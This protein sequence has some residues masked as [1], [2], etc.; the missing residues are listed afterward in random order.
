[1]RALNSLV[2]ASPIK[3]L[4][5][6]MPNPSRKP[7]VL[8]IAEA[9]N[10]ESISVA[11]VGWHH[12]RALADVADVHLVTEERNRVAI[13]KT[14]LWRAPMTAL[15]AQA[16]YQAAWKLGLKLR[17]GTGAAWTINSALYT[18][19]YPF[20]ERLVWKRFGERLQRGE[21]D[22]VHR[23]T[24]LSPTT[25]SALA[26]KCARNEIPFILG[27]MNGG[28]AWP[29]GFEEIR[30]K[31]KEWLSHVRWIYRLMPGYTSTRQ[32]ASAI[33]IASLSTWD[34]M[35]ARFQD[36][37]VY[38]P[39]NGIEAERFDHPPRHNFSQPLR[40]AY[41][42]R[43]VPFK[44]PDMAL[45]A[46]APLVR[47]GKVVFDFI[48][49]GP[50]MP[51]LRE[52]VA[53]EKLENGVKLSGWVEHGKVHQRLSESDVF[54]FPSIREFGGAVVVEAMAL[55]LV[56]IVVNYGGPAETVTERTG[57]RVPLG[58]RS[59]IV[60]GLRSV[61]TRLAADPSPLAQMSRHAQQHAL[62][63]FTWAAKAKQVL[64]VY[65]WVLRQRA[66]KPDFG[67]PFADTVAS[68]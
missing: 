26:K 60:A 46:A 18:L 53:R 50:E 19:T 32:S 9:A 29:K 33:M 7:R 24:P 30:R 3:I 59:E 67:R 40:V 10:P 41:L 48:G 47:A 62:Q 38:I 66:D 35:P 58:S 36:K 54:C 49:D 51:R 13:E 27:P 28:L 64:E 11:L 34:E 4:L 52:F 6:H 1:M 37:C 20:F 31:E 21:W 44:G 45:E 14:G 55:G 25:P 2:R 39:E 8:L 61:L 5:A 15:N 42:G 17:G 65:R 12:A 56:P 23:L 68:G 22:L 57:F 63:H 43:F 16:T